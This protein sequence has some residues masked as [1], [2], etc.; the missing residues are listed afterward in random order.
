M[1]AEVLLQG[2]WKEVRNDQTV[3]TWQQLRM[4]C[5]IKLQLQTGSYNAK[6]LCAVLHV[7]N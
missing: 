1:E 3:H 7:H 6:F 5:I 4:L 2:H